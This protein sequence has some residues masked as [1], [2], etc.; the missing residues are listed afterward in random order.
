MMLVRPRAMKMPGSHQMP[1]YMIHAPTP[2]A[3]SSW[4]TGS[5][6]TPTA[7]GVAHIGSERS[8]P[9]ARPRRTID[10]GPRKA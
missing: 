2:Q 8:T 6:A 1:A 9:V 10:A 4:K 7:S 5:T 3:S